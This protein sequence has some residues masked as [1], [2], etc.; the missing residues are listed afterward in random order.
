VYVLVTKTDL[1]HGLPSFADLGKEQRAGLRLHAQV[2]ESARIDEGL[3]TAFQGSS[4]C[5]TA[6]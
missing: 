4:N 6:A 2:D 3:A 5:R 1:L